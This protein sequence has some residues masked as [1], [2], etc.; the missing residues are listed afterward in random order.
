MNLEE[1]K[2]AWVD[3]G[4]KVSDLNAELNQAL[5]DETKSEE[6]VVGLQAQLKTARAKRDGL[7]EQV[8][9]MEA[10][11]I[12]NMKNAQKDPLDKDEKDLK[13]KFIKDFKAMIKGDPQVV[14]LINSDTD[15]SGNAIGLTI[16]SDVRTAINELVRQFDSLQE[17]VNVERVITSNGSRVYEKWS[18]ITPLK[19]LDAEDETIPDNDDPKLMLIKYL[20][21][22]YAG[23]NT[24]TNSLLKDTAENIMAW[25]SKWISKKVV[26]T[27]NT[28][29]LKAIDGIDA[30]QKKEITDV[31]GIKDI[32]NE[33][34]DPAIEA[35]SMFL[36]NQSG[37][38]VLDKVKRSDGSYLLQKDVT[39]PTGYTFLGKP[40]KKL[41]NRWLPN[42]GTK[43]SP[44]Y[45]L[46]IGDLREAVTLYDREQMSLLTTNIGGGAF[47]TDTTKVRV[48][49]RF[50]VQLVD[51]EAL[52]F[53]TFAG[54]ANETPVT[55]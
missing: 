50:D 32:V 23:I 16:P 33:Q 22:R 34:L 4:S 43:A 39:S 7:K 18:D 38:N 48:I 14:A 36:T 37:Y 45:P 17:Y 46:Y 26:V 47:E 2:N 12:E 28:K 19:E 3:A 29:I 21:K 27:R 8:V 51:E 55:P 41:S 25:L 6:E 31:D 52:V 5:I 20:I 9:N 15:E 30:A 1:L 13:A 49:D 42:G 40:I 54:I 35:T 44:K 10:E 11:Q 24:V 53:A